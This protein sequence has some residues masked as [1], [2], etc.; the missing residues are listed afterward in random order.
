M[1]ETEWLTGL[2]QKVR[3]SVGYVNPAFSSEVTLPGKTARPAMQARRFGHHIRALSA[4]D[5]GHGLGGLVRDL[6]ALF[7]GQA[8]RRGKTKDIAL[9]HGPA[10][11]A[12]FH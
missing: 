6:L 11:H 7:G 1:H 5:L 12:F 8:K 2:A 9:R 10:D 4:K 3:E